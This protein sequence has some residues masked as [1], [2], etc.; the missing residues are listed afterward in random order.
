MK[1]NGLIK[2]HGAEPVAVPEDI[3]VKAMVSEQQKSNATEGASANPT[4]DQ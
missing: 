2:V 4:G 3:D 1:N